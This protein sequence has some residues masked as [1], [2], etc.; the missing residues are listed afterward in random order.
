MVASL[1]ALG[2][3]VDASGEPWRVAG[4]R[5]TPARAER[6]ALHGQLRDHRALPHRRGVPR[7]RPRH[8]R[9]QRAHARAADRRPHARARA[10]RRAMRDRSARA[11][12]RPCASRAAGCAAA[13]PTIDARRSSQYV[14]AVLLAAPYAQRDVA[15]RFAGG[16]L[17][18]RPYVDLTLDV[19]RAFGAQR[20]VEGRRRAA[21]ARGRALPRPRA[22]RSRPTPRRPPIRS[23]PR[24]SRAA[25]CAWRASTRA[26]ASP[27]CGILDLLERMGCR[28]VRGADWAE[29]HGPA[30]RLAGIDV[31]MNELPDAVLA[32]AVVALFAEGPTR[33]RNVANLR[34]KET[35]RLAALET[36]LRKLGARAR[37]DA[38]S[39]AIEPAPLRAR[40]DRHLRRSPHGDGVRA[41]RAAP[42]RRRDPRSGLRLEDL[43]RLLRHARGS[44]AMARLPLVP[45]AARE[46]RVRGA[47]ALARATSACAQ[48]CASA[49]CANAA[50]IGDWR[51]APTGRAG[52]APR[53]A[54]RAERG[55]GRDLVSRA[56]RG[57]A[58]RRARPTRAFAGDDVVI[59]VQTHFV[60]DRPECARWNRELRALYASV[61]PHWWR[62]L[63]DV[64]AY[65]MTA[66]LRCVFGESETAVAVLTSAPGTGPDRMLLDRE[67]AGVRA[68]FERLGGGGR[69]VQPLR[70]VQPELPRRP[71]RDGDRARALRPGR[72]E[73]ATRSAQARSGV[74]VSRRRSDRHSV[75]RAGARVGR[76]ARVRAQ[77]H[78]RPGTDRLAARR[79]SRGGRV[80]GPRLPDLPLG[81][82][83]PVERRA[84]GGP[85][86]RRD[87][88]RRH[89]PARDVAARRAA[90]RR[91]R[92]SAPS[93][94]RP[95]SA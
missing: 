65:D 13:R 40:R 17:V 59:D 53:R 70:R 69:L 33:I 45:G 57:R 93:S 91:A 32:L 23:A 88:A 54:A 12:A 60:A 8:D 3:A 86:L 77:G 38:D 83:D 51:R 27:T 56:R 55:R 78:Q 37:A 28:A 2:C 90:S 52:A 22:T 16:E 73:G 47:A 18:S 89:E 48:R 50:R 1:A 14:S 44:L 19:M 20:R 15:L 35:D 21:R 66:Y 9:R 39:L 71:R 72:V 84:R 30:G 85:L 31:D 5:R 34:I 26:R 61:A 49:A 29:V 58:R 25:A 43:A 62:G 82:R 6:A 41:G 7:G 63:D 4:L 92:T 87:R 10:A 76:A 36:E 68:L 24:R 79:R 64:T 46:R 75:P 67:L 74:V 95:G 81:L 11:A 94:A 80:P 42:A